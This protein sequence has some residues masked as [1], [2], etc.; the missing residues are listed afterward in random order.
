MNKIK[1]PALGRGLSSLLKSAE[2]DVTTRVGD[3]SNLADS[4]SKLPVDKIEA[5]PFQPRTHFEEEAL[6]ELT[7]SIKTYGIIQPVT[8]RKLGYDKYQLIS[9]ERRFR[10]SQLAGLTEIPA[11]IRIAND[12]AMLEMAL[13]E[14]IQRS[15]LDA[16]EVAISFKRLLDE[17]KITQE[18]LSDRV[19]KNR[20][21]V[22]NYLRLLKLPPEIQLGIRKRLITMGHARALVSVEN[23][24]EQLRVFEKAVLEQLSVREVEQLIQGLTPATSA[25]DTKKSKTEKTPASTKHYYVADQLSSKLSTP[26]QVKSS[27][28]GRG[29]I[30]INF[31]DEA[32]FLRISEKL[33]V[34]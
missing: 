22:T 14:N 13:V 6:Q 3:T 9:G 28:K 15:D 2:T 25:K 10:A 24:T 20:T 32:E 27:P 29:F 18:E 30:T 26:V 17:C 23:P 34:K 1:K 21:T 12:Q 7:E 31:K 19:S 16:V 11:Y 5:N 33:G 4:I 8:V